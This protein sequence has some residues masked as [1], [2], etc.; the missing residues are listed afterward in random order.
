MIAVP[1]VLKSNKKLLK[2]QRNGGFYSF[3]QEIE[4]GK[5]GVF[6]WHEIYHKSMK[7]NPLAPLIA[8]KQDRDKVTNESL[9]KN[10][11]DFL[12]YTKPRVMVAHSKGCQLIN[13]T[14]L[15]YGLPESIKIIV[16]MQSDDNYYSDL[17]KL[18]TQCNLINLY[19]ND[20]A[21]L[22][23]SVLINKGLI[24]AGLKPILDKNVENKLYKSKGIHIKSLKDQDIKQWLLT[25]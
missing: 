19:S 8:Y 1:S 7:L 17:S 9:Q 20:D 13:L 4:D 15:K 14:F 6:L 18:A 12:E 11:F 2:Q 22:W 3:D 5:V 24:R 16:F 10:L 21:T 25:L 23:T